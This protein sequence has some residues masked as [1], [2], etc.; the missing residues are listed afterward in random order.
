M[1]EEC[2]ISA[3]ATSQLALESTQA[4]RVRVDIQALRGWAVLVVVLYHTGLFPFLG[5]GYLGVDIF[6][7]VSGYLITGLVQRSLYAGAFTFA[8]FYARRAKRLLPA[9]YAM[10]IATTLVS[11]QVLTSNESREFFAQLI[12]AVTF[13][14]NIVLWS[15]AG[16]FAP[17]ASMKP[18]LHM[19]S[20]SIE[21]Q[22]Y[23]L[24]PAALVFVPRRFWTTGA[25]LV[26]LT[27]LAICLALV[28]IKPGVAF[29]F[30]PARAWELALGSVGA[31][32]LE[33]YREAPWVRRSFW[34]ALVALLALPFLPGGMPHPG[35]AAVAVCVSTLA[36]ILGRVRALHQSWPVVTMAKL[37]DMSY[38]LYLVHWPMMAL[39]A[40]A[41][42]TEIPPTVR[43][44]LMVGSFIFAWL[45]YRYVEQPA[46]AAPVTPRMNLALIVGGVVLV[47]L[48]V[49]GLQAESRVGSPV[50]EFRAG[51]H[52]LNASCDYRDA[53]S[54]KAECQT[55]LA[56]RIMVWGDS[57]AMHLMQ[58]I[59]ATAPDVVQ[60]TKSSCGP[61]LS[62]SMFRVEDSYNKAWGIECIRFNNGVLDF[63]SR[64]N[65]VD[66]VVL[67]SWF[68]QYL[69][70]RRI[71]SAPALRAES[72]IEAE[73]SVDVA[74][75]SLRTTVTELRKSGKRVVLV[76]TPPVGGFDV[77]RCLEMRSQGKMRLGADFD[78]CEISEQAYRVARAEVLTML[79]RIE[80]EAFV[81]VVH[82][83]RHLCAKGTCA[84]EIDGVPLYRD[85]GHLSVEGSKALGLKLNLGALL[86]R[87][88]R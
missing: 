8:S 86:Q 59:A 7:V 81:P 60:A 43:A 13:T 11:L 6:F 78:N 41:W 25:A 18:L 3:S 14:S 39:A 12:G 68:G 20:L 84:A 66:V 61:L 47:L 74:I 62:I 88:A 34:P 49:L 9:A 73:G 30:L 57:Q 82:L 56:P 23:L 29:Y 65:S 71:V 4:A 45:L 51:N 15:Q 22:Y 76:A 75:A 28:P 2:V 32:A 87:D 40:N 42:L 58:A 85:A 21:E 50:R 54:P 16:Y 36:V 77:G 52:G 27:S 19:W 72:F 26:C 37:G 55:S 67:A 53:F 63:L 35:L 69:P 17:P 46:R 38:S 83:D 44:A 10:L 5:S 70:G 33:R 31:I 1:T 48:G 64:S 80:A 24:L 79:E